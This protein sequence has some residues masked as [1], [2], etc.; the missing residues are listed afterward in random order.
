MKYTGSFKDFKSF[1]T[2]YGKVT[3]HPSTVRNLNNILQNLSLIYNPE[4][5]QAF[6]KLLAEHAIDIE[7]PHDIEI[8]NLSENILI[9]I[10]EKWL[11][12]GNHDSY[13]EF[14]VIFFSAIYLAT[15][16]EQLLSDSED[17]TVSVRYLHKLLYLFHTGPFYSHDP[18]LDQMFIGT[19]FDKRIIYSVYDTLNPSLD[20][21][22]PMKY[23]YGTYVIEFD[24]NTIQEDTYYFLATS[25][26]NPDIPVVSIYR[27]RLTPLVFCMDINDGISQ[28]KITIPISLSRYRIVISTNDDVIDIGICD[29]QQNKTIYSMP[30][31][32][33]PN[34]AV[35]DTKRTQIAHAK[36]L[37]YY[38]MPV[39][40]EELIY[41]L[42]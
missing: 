26:S 5:L 19:T 1:T 30:R 23:N 10:Y 41:L 4:Q 13:E 9:D 11:T 32:T 38:G 6:R 16:D 31:I 8:D 12:Y 25:V 40:S 2:L 18:I 29:S 33:N 20:I 39:S 27:K 42:T 22:E 37:Q 34:N 7:D 36:C 3:L 17:L 24:V 21:E 15:T 28:D 14:K 35:G